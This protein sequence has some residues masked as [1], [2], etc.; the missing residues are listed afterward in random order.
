M[1]EVWLALIAV[2]PIALGAAFASIAMRYVS[3]S[4]IDGMTRQPDI[5]PQLFTAMLIGMALI[6]A[7]SI[8]TLVVTWSSRRRSDPS[9]QE[10]ARMNPAELNLN[11][12]SQID[13]VV[14]LVVAVIMIVLYLLLRRFF[15]LPYLEVMEAREELFAVA[16]ERTARLSSIRRESDLEAEAVLTEAAASAEGCGA[17]PRR[18]PTPIGRNASRRPRWR[19]RS[20]SIR[21]APSCA[22]FTTANG[23]RCGSR[24]SSASLSHASSCLGAPI[25]RRS[26]APSPESWS[27]RPVRGCLHCSN[28]WSWPS[29]RSS[30]RWALRSPPARFA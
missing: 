19:P 18:G 8:Y 20:H 25:P 21:A 27:T 13:P 15:V 29:R 16:R 4:A 12:L 3:T 22:R 26:R 24:R 2:L 11:P 23:P 9:L 14:I 6:E 5:A 17:L 10:A 28:R 1:N 7:L 30:R